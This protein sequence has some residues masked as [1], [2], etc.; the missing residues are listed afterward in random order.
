MKMDDPQQPNP[1]EHGKLDKLADALRGLEKE[2]VFVPSK[3]DD[4][5]IAQ[6]RKHFGSTDTPSETDSLPESSQSITP[7]SLIFHTKPSKIRIH[8]R[9][10]RWHRWLPLAA[11]IAIAAIVL[12][13][14]RPTTTVAGDVNRDGT[15]DVLDAFLL[16]Q[17]VQSG[18]ETARAWDVNG[19]KKIDARD[20]DE[21]LARIVD[22]E[23]SG[24]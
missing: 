1:E 7:E 20:A 8:P 2:R 6:V 13:F 11:S 12:F 10:K 18:G 5:I 24:L 9:V 19:D 23:R 15:L 16:A 4:A 22:L 17:R 3:V 21:I 14:S